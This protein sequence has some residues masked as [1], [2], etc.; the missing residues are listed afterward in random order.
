MDEMVLMQK[1][2]FCRQDESHDK[3]VKP[4]D[5]SEDQD[6]DHTHKKT[7]L[8]GCSSHAG[9]AHD[10]DGKTSRKTAEAHAQ[11][12]AEVEETPVGKISEKRILSPQ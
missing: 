8:L 12:S 1:L 3:T 4:Q 9:V 6:Q 5:L 2:L 10:A 7:G 11:T